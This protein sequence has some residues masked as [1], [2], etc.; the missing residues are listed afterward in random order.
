[1]MTA[2]LGRWWLVCGRPKRGASLLPDHDVVRQ[3][4]GRDASGRVCL[5]A[6]QLGVSYWAGRRPASWAALTLKSRMRRRRAAVDIL[7]RFE[8]LP[9]VNVVLERVKYRPEVKAVMQK[10]YR[11]D[12]G[13]GDAG[14]AVRD[15]L[16]VRR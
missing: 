8:C 13:K 12:V 14:E 11:W 5:H 16:G 9:T 10:Q 4:R 15:V 6:L 1:M 3:R 2:F 7:V